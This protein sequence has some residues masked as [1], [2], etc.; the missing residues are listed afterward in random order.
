MA[1]DEAEWVGSL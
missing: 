1:K